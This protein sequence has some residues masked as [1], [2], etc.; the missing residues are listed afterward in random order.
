M[1]R[2]RARE[3]FRARN[4][5]SQLKLVNHDDGSDTA[6]TQAAGELP[7]IP[8]NGGS[9][10][11][12]GGALGQKEGHAAQSSARPGGEDPAAAAAGTA[13]QAGEGKAA[14]GGPGGAGTGGGGGGEEDGQ[15]GQAMVRV[16]G[17]KGAFIYVTYIL[18]ILQNY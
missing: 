18:Y 9:G 11:E 12:D 13:L 16:M 1:S 6:A 8:S 14:A 4:N 5:A 7:S 10:A 2:K 15:F 3:S 17:K